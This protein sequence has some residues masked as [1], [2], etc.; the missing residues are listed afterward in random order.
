MV[1][2]GACAEFEIEIVSDF[3][4]ACGYFDL[5]GRAVDIVEQLQDIVSGGGVTGYDDGVRR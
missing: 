2:D 4:D 3:E 5:F 1:N